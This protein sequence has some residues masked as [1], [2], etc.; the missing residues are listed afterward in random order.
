MRHPGGWRAPTG[1]RAPRH[2]SPQSGLHPPAPTHTHACTLLQVV[3][4]APHNA[5][6]AEP[7][8]D[9]F[10]AVTSPLAELGWAAR[11]AAQNHTAGGSAESPGEGGG[12]STSRPR[13]PRALLSPKRVGAHVAAVLSR[14]A[15]ESGI[16]VS[17]LRKRRESGADDDAAEEEAEGMKAASPLVSSINRPASPAVSPAVSPAFVRRKAS[18]A[19]RSLGGA[20]GWP[21]VSRR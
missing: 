6:G 4:L 17:P 15:A 20:D 9:R 12:R 11:G 7:S 8:Y 16:G 1:P 10:K 5:Y 14:V 21:T 13:P 19:A 2:A 18:T 3:R